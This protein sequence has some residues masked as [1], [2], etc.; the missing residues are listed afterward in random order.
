MKLKL[1]IIAILFVLVSQV[2]H[3]RPLR[4]REPI[5]FYFGLNIGFVLAWN[6]DFNHENTKSSVGFNIGAQAINSINCRHCKSLLLESSIDYEH[7]GKYTF[8]PTRVG[9]TRIAGR[10]KE[11]LYTFHAN[12]GLRYYFLKSRK[13]SPFI[14][15]TPGIYYTKIKSVSFKDF[16]GNDID[17]GGVSRSSVNFG[18]GFGL[19]LS[20]R[21]SHKLIAE[22]YPKWHIYFPQGLRNSFLQLPLT[23]KYRF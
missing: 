6:D 13:L 1:I 9:N 7:L 10:Y 12:F 23:L 17:F 3:A 5:R 20:Y 22:F 16:S 11:K 2:A 8:S 18:F 4:Y 15:F 14:S 19:G 21:L